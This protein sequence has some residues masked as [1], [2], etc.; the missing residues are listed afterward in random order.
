[1]KKINLLLIL[2]LFLGATT[3]VFADNSTTVTTTVPTA[4]YVLTIPADQNVEYGTTKAEIGNV[5]VTNSSGFA[6]GKNL[7]VTVEHDV[8]TSESVDTTIPYELSQNLQ[9][10]YKETST[11]YKP[12]DNGSTLTFI[13]QSNGTV[14]SEA[15]LEFKLTSADAMVTGTVKNLALNI[16]QSDWAKALAGDY[17]TTITFT[18]EV[19]VE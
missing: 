12:L 15:R 6:Y 11:I 17:S 16:E 14:M 18:A 4:Q 19:L 9:Y 10:Y 7:V 8:F 5:T 1:M 13:G 3:S 2:C